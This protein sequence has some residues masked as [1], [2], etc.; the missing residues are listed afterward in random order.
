MQA[1]QELAKDLMRHR[2]S[3]WC[4]AELDQVKNL[5]LNPLEE[6][7]R[8]GPYDGCAEISFAGVASAAMS[9]AET[10]TLRSAA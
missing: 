4:G 8:L 10:G 3:P 5:P 2:L 9:F 7:M 6:W 1:V